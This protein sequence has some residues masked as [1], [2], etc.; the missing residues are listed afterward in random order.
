MVK[1][2]SLH[3]IFKMPEQKTSNEGKKFKRKILLNFNKHTMVY[4][5]T[6]VRGFWNLTQVEGTDVGLY[7]LVPQRPVKQ[8]NPSNES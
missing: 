6:Y 1:N 2:I 3:N 4:D 7:F 5:H 8:E